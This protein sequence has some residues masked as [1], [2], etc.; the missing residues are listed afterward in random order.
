[1]RGVRFSHSSADVRKDGESDGKATKR[2][3][4]SVVQLQRHY[5]TNDRQFEDALVAHP[6]HD[7]GAHQPPELIQHE[8]RPKCP[9]Y[10]RDNQN[11]DRDREPPRRR[12]TVE[13]YSLL[14][15]ILTGGD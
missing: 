7:A 15:P 14:C 3:Y 13:G 6:Q 4:V 8:A 11:Q 2:P 9:S 1:M 5:S 10:R 12:D